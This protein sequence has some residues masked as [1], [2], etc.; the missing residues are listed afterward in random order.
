VERERESPRGFLIQTAP[1]NRSDNPRCPTFPFLSLLSFSVI[2]AG[3]PPVRTLDPSRSNA[4]ECSVLP[5]TVYVDTVIPFSFIIQCKKL[6][7]QNITQTYININYMQSICEKH[8]KSCTAKEIL[9][10]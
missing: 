4:S 3:S 8:F 6:Y 9:F 2:L 10:F 5:H 7:E 1:G